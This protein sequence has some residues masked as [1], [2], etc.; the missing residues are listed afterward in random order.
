M[1]GVF[2]LLSEKP[3]ASRTFLGVQTSQ[4]LVRRSDM[5]DSLQMPGNMSLI[6]PSVVLL[7]QL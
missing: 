6:I 5:V 1:K 3:L 4:G 2:G 7:L